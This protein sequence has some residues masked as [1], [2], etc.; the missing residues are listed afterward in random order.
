VPDCFTSSAIPDAAPAPDEALV[1]LAGVHKIKAVKL[2][3]EEKRR[4]DSIASQEVRSRYLAARCLV[5][6]VLASWLK[7]EPE[8]IPLAISSEGKP[9]V[10]G[11]GK[12][13][14]SIS[15]TEDLVAVALFHEAV[16]IDLE[17][18][19]PIDTVAL[20][21]RF[22]SP[23][24]AEYLEKKGSSSDFFRLWSCREAAIKGDGR[25]MATLLAEMKI[26]PS[27]LGKTGPIRVAV[28][29]VS[30]SAFPW[31]LESNLHSAV[32]FREEPRL[33][34]WCDLR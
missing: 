8:E 4:A 2:P 5:R 3:S 27:E 23:E 21:R 22:F 30:W 32:A 14:F 15:H 26:A 10:V 13:H 11:E 9:F 34:R 7:Q 6:S 31:M 24:E 19:R 16:G 17:R 29:D 25:G 1:I 12:P 28:E 33:I 18:E 20:A